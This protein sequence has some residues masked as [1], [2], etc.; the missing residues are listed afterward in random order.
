MNLELALQTSQT[1]WQWKMMRALLLAVAAL[2]VLAARVGAAPLRTSADFDALKRI[3]TIDVVREATRRA[4]VRLIFEHERAE[5]LAK[6]EATEPDLR[7][8]TWLAYLDEGLDRHNLHKVFVLNYGDF[9]PQILQS[10]QHAR[11]EHEAAIFAQAMALF[12]PRYPL[13]QKEREPYFGPWGK[14]KHILNVFDHA[15]MALAVSFGSRQRFAEQVTAYVERTPSLTAFADSSR[16]KMTE[17][18]RLDWLLWHLP[19]TDWTNPRSAMAAWPTPYRQL[20]F[21]R[22]FN[23]EMQNGGVHQFFFNSSGDFAPEVVAAMREVGLLRHADALQRALDMFDKPYPSDNNERRRRYFEKDWSDWDE[24]L[25]AP[26]YEVDDGEIGA[27][28]LA[29]AKHEGVLPR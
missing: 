22:I 3:P 7:A 16:E 27:T 1:P 9:A 2:L 19:V 12:G 20:F 4:T 21:L 15:L 29:I 5:T 11:L 28:M 10:L 18:E 14:H 8:L 23:I 13:D 25:N 24:E 26:T 6:I 17:E